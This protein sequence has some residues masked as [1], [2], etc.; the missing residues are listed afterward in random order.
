MIVGQILLVNLFL[1]FVEFVKM[2]LCFEASNL[3]TGS[4]SFCLFLLDAGESNPS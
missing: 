1:H 2:S 4:C 3:D